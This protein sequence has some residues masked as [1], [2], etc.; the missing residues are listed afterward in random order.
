MT[1]KKTPEAVATDPHDRFRLQSLEQILSIFDGGAFMDEV[2]LGHRQLQMDLLDHK[3]EHGPKGCQGSMTITVNYALGKSGDV[4]MGATV[5]FKAPKK[6]PASAAAY[7]DEDGNLTLFSPLL[8]R[9]QEP[10]RDASAP[11]DVTDF[12]PETGEIRDPA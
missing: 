4:G 7:I 8:K 12:D 2:L 1:Q 6:P 11:R 9:M 3:E 5:A 10:V